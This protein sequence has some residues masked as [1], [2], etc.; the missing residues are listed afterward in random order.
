[1]ILPVLTLSTWYMAAFIRFTRSTFIEAMKSDYIVVARSK[2]I[3][4][5]RVL[6]L[7]AF[8]NTLIPLVTVLG[9]NISGLFGGAVVTESVFALP[10]LGRLLV[11]SILGRDTPLMMGIVIFITVLVV[12]CNLVVD[13][14]YVLIDPRIRYS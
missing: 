10:G 13:L 7:H 11:D 3:L 6:W 1:M 2:G 5:R 8:K 4:E 9:L 14:I 12:V